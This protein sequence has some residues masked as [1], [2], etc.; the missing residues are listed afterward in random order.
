VLIKRSASRFQ[1]TNKCR[2]ETFSLEAQKKT[3]RRADTQKISAWKNLLQSDLLFRAESTA[4]GRILLSLAGAKNRR[5][6]Y[7]DTKIPI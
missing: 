5:K 4:S 6:R 2:S 1:S 3:Y 7:L